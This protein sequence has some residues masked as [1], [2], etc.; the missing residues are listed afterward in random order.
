[1]GGVAA[2]M[3]VVE[4]GAG[5]VQLGHDVEI[6]AGL[7]ELHQTLEL[8]TGLVEVLEDLAAENIVVAPLQIGGVGI[9]K[10]VVER[11]SVAEGPELGGNHRAGAATVVE[12]TGARR[13][14]QQDGVG[15]GGGETLVAKIMHIVVVHLVN[16]ALLVGRHIV[17]VVLHQS[18]AVVTRKIK[19]I[20]G[21][22]QGSKAKGTVH[23]VGYNGSGAER[24]L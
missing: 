19:S 23:F 14:A 21:L 9:E 24:L 17:T 16:A 12:T 20:D 8:L 6:P 11:N 4:R 18:A 1:M 7:Q 15:D 5:T 22:L 3:P 10:R 13:V 2:V